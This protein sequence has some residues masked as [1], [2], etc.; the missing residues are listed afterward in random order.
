M[1]WIVMKRI[2]CRNRIV[3]HMRVCVRSASIAY[4]FVQNADPD[5]AGRNHLS[6]PSGVV[7]RP[8]F[9]RNKQNFALETNT[10]ME[11]SGMVTQFDRVAYRA[12]FEA[13]PSLRGRANHYRAPAVH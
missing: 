11:I 9:Q 7:L 6:E 2:I 8:T 10:P 1:A 4:F 12:R 3:M 5:A 13:H